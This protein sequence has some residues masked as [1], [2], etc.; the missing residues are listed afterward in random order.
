VP[1][2]TVV[3]IGVLFWQ[4]EV[5]SKQPE[6]GCTRTN[7]ISVGPDS[8]IGGT[9]ISRNLYGQA[10]HGA[11]RTLSGRPPTCRRDAGDPLEKYAGLVRR[12]GAHSSSMC[13][14]IL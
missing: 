6:G 8:N 2:G 11:D 1:F 10:V 13:S 5:L 7:K 12:A 9:D 4:P 3:P 14:D